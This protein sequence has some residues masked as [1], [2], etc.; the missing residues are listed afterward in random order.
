MRFGPRATGHPAACLAAC[1][2]ALTLAACG[3]SSSPVVRP[4]STAPTTG[5][6]ATSPSTLTSSTQPPTSTSTRPGKPTVTVTPDHK[7]ADRQQVRVAA[8]GFTPG[9]AL[10]VVQCADRGTATGPGDCN[11][12]GMTPVVA[13]AQGTVSVTMQVLRGPFGSNRIVCGQPH[14]C[15]ISVTQATLSPTEEAD[16]R[17]TFG[18]GG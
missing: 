10:Q 6:S 7:L 13:D 2:A 9:E 8:A 5:P 12:T 11:L 4:G 18:P 3:K 15:L 1:L 17:I 16:A 14:P